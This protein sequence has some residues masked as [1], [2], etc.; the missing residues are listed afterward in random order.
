MV[1]PGSRSLAASLR[2]GPQLRA[3]WPGMRMRP[4]P[5]PGVPGTPRGPRQTWEIGED[6]CFQISILG[7]HT[8]GRLGECMNGNTDQVSQTPSWWVGRLPRQPQHSIPD[9]LRQ[10]KRILSLF[11]GWT[12]PATFGQGW[13][14]PAS[15]PPGACRRLLPPCSVLTWPLSVSARFWSLSLCPNLF[16]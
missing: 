14:L 7:P 5:T 1:S 10:Q 4:P 9:G 8:R 12:S 16:L 13:F 2:A 3:R 15:L 11:R 6:V